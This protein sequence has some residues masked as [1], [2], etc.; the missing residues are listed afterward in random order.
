MTTLRC[1]GYQPEASVH[2]RALRHLA[3]AFASR[4]DVRVE[5]TADV[6]ATGRRAA[7]LPTLVETGALDLCYFASSY[8]A[9]RVPALG[10]FDIPF[11]VA[12]RA[13]IYAALDRSLGA[14][15]AAAVAAATG[16]RVLG[17]WDNGFRHIS[18]RLR[19]LRHPDDCRGLRLRTLDNA[20]H[21]EIFSTLGFTPMVVD[22]KD[23]ADAVAR[24]TVDA[25][26]NP[27]TNL[28]NFNLHKTHRHVSLTAHFFGV[29]LLLVNRAWFDALPAGTRDA[30]VAAAAEA[31]A[32]QRDFAQA[33]DARCLE[34]LAADGVAVVAADEIDRAAFKAKLAPIISREANK[35]GAEFFAA[36]G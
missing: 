26:E 25:Q 36:L 21:Q 7:D 17:F 15:L 28:V 11:A 6:T 8:L 22:V 2:T 3:A 10:V 35:I 9:G 12:D 23:L 16:Y 29:A 27:L 18:N 31:T 30:L 4:P 5:V 1:G 14:T 34:L 19:P 33:E 20:L 24:G 13:R 32:K